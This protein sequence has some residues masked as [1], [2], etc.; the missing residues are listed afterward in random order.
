MTGMFPILLT[1]AHAKG[2]KNTRG[3]QPNLSSSNMNLG[4]P[5]ILFSGV[6]VGQVRD[7]N[8]LEPRHA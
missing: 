1:D 2:S 7:T 6:Y 4:R 5:K 8:P 3:M